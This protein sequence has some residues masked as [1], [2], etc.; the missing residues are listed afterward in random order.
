MNLVSPNWVVHLVSIIVLYCIV[1]CCYI[2]IYI[3]GYSVNLNI[4]TTPFYSPEDIMK[5]LDNCKV[6]KKCSKPLKK[7]LNALGDMVS[8]M[9]VTFTYVYT[10]HTN[11]YTVH[12]HLYTVHTHLYTAPT[13]LYTAPT[14][15]YTAPTHLYTAHTHLYTAHTH[16]HIIHS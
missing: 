4:C 6:P 1:F 16:L 2:H 9:L 10:A 3:C 8:S 14:H 13:H 12:T 15:L 11:L 5:V 7:T